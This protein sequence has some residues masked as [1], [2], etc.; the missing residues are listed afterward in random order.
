MS[1]SIIANVDY[2]LSGYDGLYLMLYHV[3][4]AAGLSGITQ[5]QAM[6]GGSSGKL[7]GA[8]YFA[9]SKEVANAKALRKGI[10]LVALVEVGR[11]MVLMNAYSNVTKDKL[12][13]VGCSCIKSIYSNGAEYIIYNP[14]LVK[15]VW[16]IEGDPAGPHVV[17]PANDPRPEC[18]YGKEC[19][20][21]KPWHFAKYKH[22]LPPKF[23]MR[24][25]T[26][27]QKPSC[28]YGADCKKKD[29]VHFTR[30]SHPPA[31]PVPKEGPKPSTQPSTRYSSN[32]PKCRYG[33]EC[34]RTN[35][36]HFKEYS[37]PVGFKY[38]CMYKDKCTD[39]SP[40]HLRKYKHP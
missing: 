27:D 34:T 22:L 18:K 37:H 33:M 17:F 35:P 23:P 2:S 28:K 16:V 26:P 31:T 24:I 39:R 30:Y 13:Q 25:P 9:D 3:T 32:L 40:E 1:G 21:K 11:I 5:C 29:V 10:T 6:K 19:N 12:D 8:I 15:A 7:G 20:R 36:S 4:G 38:M 14:S